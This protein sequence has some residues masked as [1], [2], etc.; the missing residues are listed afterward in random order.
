MSYNVSNLSK[1]WHHFAF[2]FNYKTGATYY[3]DSIP[4]NNISFDK[5]NYISYDLNTFLIL[6]ATTVKNTILNNILNVN[7]G[8]KYVGSVGDLKMYNITLNQND[9]EELYYSS[10]FAPK[11]KTL[12][13]NMKVGTRNYIEEINQ[14]FQFQLPTNKS[15]YYN[16]NVHNLNLDDNIKKNIELAINKII[17]KLSPAHTELNKINWK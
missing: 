15:K 5:N 8:Y 7:E 3:I 6:G 10:I 17:G 14:W 1:G 13:W 4:V 2:T 11:I 9:I 16:I 12:K